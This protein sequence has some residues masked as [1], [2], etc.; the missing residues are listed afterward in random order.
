MA[1]SLDVCHHAEHAASLAFEEAGHDVRLLVRD[2]QTR[3]LHWTGAAT[4]GSAWTVEVS[5]P[6]GA[7]RVEVRSANG[8]KGEAQLVVDSLAPSTARL[9]ITARR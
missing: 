5:V 1:G 4:K 9:E 8:L 6:I 3:R 2:P 7:H